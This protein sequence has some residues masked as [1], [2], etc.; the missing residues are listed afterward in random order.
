LEWLFWSSLSSGHL[1]IHLDPSEILLRAGNN[2]LQEAKEAGSL[3][4]IIGLALK[5]RFSET[6]KKK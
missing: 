5:A 1:S 6:I 2:I 3:I 4:G